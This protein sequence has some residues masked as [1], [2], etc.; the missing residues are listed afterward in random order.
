MT[1]ME[2]NWVSVLDNHRNRKQKTLNHC[3][4]SPIVVC[5]ILRGCACVLH[6]NEV[7][8]NSFYHVPLIARLTSDIVSLSLDSF[9]CENWEKKFSFLL[10]LIETKI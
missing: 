3:T 6:S 8:V 2:G 7:K 5:L 4:D 1:K 10:L 9:D